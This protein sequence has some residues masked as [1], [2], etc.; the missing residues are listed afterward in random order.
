MENA[1]KF[2][3]HFKEFETGCIYTLSDG[4]ILLGT[5]Y[6]NIGDMDGLTDYHTK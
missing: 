6:Q 4:T 1:Y 2:L 3:L 5:P